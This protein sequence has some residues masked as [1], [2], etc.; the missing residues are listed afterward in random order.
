MVIEQCGAPKQTGSLYCLEHA[1]QQKC[2]RCNRRLRAGLFEQ[3][4]NTCRSCLSVEKT[5]RERRIQTGGKFTSSVNNTFVVESSEAEPNTSDPKVFCQAIKPSF[6][7]SLSKAIQKR[8][9]KWYPTLKASFIRHTTGGMAMIEPWF[10]APSQILLRPD[11]IDNQLDLAIETVL[12]RL[13]AFEGLG[14][15][16]ILS[17]LICVDLMIA[18]YNPVGGSSYIKLPEYIANKK[19]VINI[20]NDDNLCFTYSILAG[21]YPADDHPNRVYHYKKHINKLCLDGL[22]FP[23]KLNDITKFEKQNPTISVGVIELTTGNRFVPIY[24][25]KDRE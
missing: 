23:I 15:G 10:L 5:I 1:S 21:L 14:S 17:E 22:D 11:Q 7:A 9:I 12:K 4:S 3:D 8:A 20:T 2:K 24:A 13:D 18:T 6:A 25:S 16:W 19:A